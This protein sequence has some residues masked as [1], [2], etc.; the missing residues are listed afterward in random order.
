MSK[1]QHFDDIDL[2]QFVDGELDDTSA[3]LLAARLESASTDENSDDIALKVQSLDQMSDT[4]RSYFELE[5]DH[6]EPRLDAMWEIIEQDIAKTDAKEVVVERAQT[7]EQRKGVWAAIVQFFEG[8]RGHIFTGAVA[9][10]AAAA[11]ILAFR[12]PK[13]VIIE[14]P[15]AIVQPSATTSPRANADKPSIPDTPDMGPGSSNTPTLMFVEDD[16]TTPEIE[17]LDVIG[18]SGTVFMVPSEGEDDVSATVIFVDFDDMEGP[19]L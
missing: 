6:A 9:A 7:R 2:M 8:Y 4:L 5:T 12:P 3:E 19:I 1:Q 18:G 11:V 17:E 10:G 13:E 14:R 15:I 16:P